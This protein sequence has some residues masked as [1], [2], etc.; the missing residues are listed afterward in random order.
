[1]TF[2]VA[3]PLVRTLDVCWKCF[4]NKF[5]NHYSVSETYAL[6]AAHCVKG[7]S[8]TTINL[9]VG[10]HDISK[11]TETTFTANYKVVSIAIHP[12]ADIAVIRTVRMKFND[13]VGP[14]CMPFKYEK[15]LFRSST[16]VAAGWG[17]TEFGGP[18]SNILKKVNLKTIP[19]VEC[20]TTHATLTTSEICTFT[21]GKDTCQYDSGTGLHFTAT[22]RLY[23]IGVVSKRTECASGPAINARVTSVLPWI[24]T[25]TP[26]AAYCDI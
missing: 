5:L 8:P 17:S 2:S 12:T 18:V 21:E 20:K 15:D 23:I 7:K 11:G 13:K 9:R 19:N 10:E 24:V 16:V 14:V 1:M 4:F 22:S 26:E 25:K 6:T 3:R